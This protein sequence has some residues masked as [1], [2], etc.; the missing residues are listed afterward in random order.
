MEKAVDD[1]GAT[2]VEAVGLRVGTQSGAVPE[3]LAGAWPIATA[4]TRLQDARLDLDVVPATIWCPTCGCEQP[5]DE[6][7]ALTCPVCG[8][9]SGA[10]V[11]GRE[12]QVTYADIEGAT[13]PPTTAKP[14][15]KPVA[16][17]DSSGAE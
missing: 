15:A 10:M 12:F 13:H 1:A 11:H 16:P 17:G 7:Y 3:V 2:S 8:T 14:S 5:I 4:G 6:F 9:P